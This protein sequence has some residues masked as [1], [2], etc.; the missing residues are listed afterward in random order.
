MPARAPLD[1]VRALH[2]VRVLVASGDRRFVRIAGFL[3]E[4]RGFL[5][6]A[7]RGVD[8]VLGAV[9]RH[10]PHVVILD[11]SESPG[12]SSRSAATIEALHPGVR[13]IVVADNGSN[14][15]RATDVSW[16][17]F[18]KWTSMSELVGQ[19]ERTY[20]GLGSP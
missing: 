6:S 19:V 9:D 7:V 11:G 17:H 14:G 12:G 16:P 15:D 20:L 1:N 3:L 8:H 2:P 13:V 4:R 10:A 18:P 5:V